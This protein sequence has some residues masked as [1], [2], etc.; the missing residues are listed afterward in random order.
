MCACNSSSSVHR[1]IMPMPELAQWDISLILLLI[2][3]LDQCRIL[4]STYMI[5]PSIYL[6]IYLLSIYLLSIYLLAIYLSIYL[7]YKVCAKDLPKTWKQTQLDSL[8]NM[9]WVPS[10][11]TSSS[12]FKD[13]N[14][15]NGTL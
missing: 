6:S 5:Y 9:G 11:H 1:N 4:I 15:K 14:A 12:V 13:K 7:Y 10:G 3:E 2:K 8:K